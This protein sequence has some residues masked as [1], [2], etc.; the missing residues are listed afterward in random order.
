MKREVGVQGAS[1]LSKKNKLMIKILTFVNVAQKNCF[2]GEHSGAFS[3]QFINLYPFRKM[4]FMA[5]KKFNNELINDNYTKCK[6]IPGIASFP[7]YLL[8]IS[9]I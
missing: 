1:P 5:L 3:V 4:I 7:V 8:K 2:F 6:K 9:L